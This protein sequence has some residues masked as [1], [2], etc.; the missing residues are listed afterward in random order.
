MPNVRTRSSWLTR[1]VILLSFCSLFA[2]ISTEMLYPILPL[3]LTGV[4]GAGGS[5]VGLIDGVAQATQNIVQ[6]FSGWASDRMQRRKPIALAGYLLS[7]L[8]KPITGLA[9]A[10]PMVLGVRFLDRV[11]AGTR[12]AP[13]DA[14]IAAAAAEEHRGKAFGLEGVGDNLGAFLGP[15]IAVLLLGAF[16]L[17][18]RVIFYL[19]V[20]PGLLAFAI[21]LF[22]REEH[23]DFAAKAKVDISLR[24]FPRA[25]WKYLMATGLF[26]IGNSSN[27]FL[28]LET[29]AAGASVEN[30]V[31]VYA[32]FNLVAALVSYPT[33]FL[34]DHLGRRNLLL[35]AF[36]VFFVAYG[37]F[38]LSA[39]VWIVAILFV[40]YGAYQGTFRT[41][42]KALAADFVPSE[43]RAG[44][45]G[46]YS[47]LVGLT[48][49]LAS[50]IAGLLWDRLGHLAVFIYGAV[51]AVVGT[52]ATL[53]LVPSDSPKSTRS[54]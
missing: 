52:A 4:L 15:L 11:G 54:S 48:Q 16:R 51:F 50:L 47:S 24:R 35:A 49:L 3:F 40:C 28:I 43:L 12:S 2:D 26:C 22:V 45:I 19:T 5:V 37:G 32:G 18:M 7:A 33:G 13:R 27:A 46:W 6:G 29:Q 31:L 10:W 21:V 8:S 25:Y 9:S 41:V 14:L 39:N 44:G 23:V 30:T 17:D 38:A 34:S 42:G 1:D 36:A 53:I 20:I